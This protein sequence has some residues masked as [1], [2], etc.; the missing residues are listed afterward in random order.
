MGKSKFDDEPPPVHPG[1]WPQGATDKRPEKKKLNG[2]SQP[3]EVVPIPKGESAFSLVERDIPDP[4][5]LCDPWATEG[6]NII[7]GRP[8]L[9]KTT[10]ERQKLAAAATGGDYLDSKFNSPIKCAF[11]SLEEGELLCRLKFKAAG[12]PE[13]ALASIQ[14]HFEWPRGDSGVQLLDRYLTENPDIRLVC[15]D[16]LTRFRMIPDVRMPAFMADYDAINLLHEMAKK[17]PGVVIDVIHHT[18]KAKSDDPIDDVS[19]TYGLTAACDSVTVLRHHADGALM[20]VAGRMWTRSENQYLM[21]RGERQ[22]WQFVGVNLGLTDQQAQ[23]YEII[24][25]DSFGIGGKELGDKLGITQPS[26]WYLINQ[27]QEA[28]VVVRRHG[29]AYAK[30]KM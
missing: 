14:L 28:G 2:S 26:A 22:S 8:K 21:R 24:K 5:R 4:V 25:A 13:S 23:A 17:H 10:L 18:R 15:I 19:G 27:L 12:F 9:G 1:E 7:A 11:L 20:Y 16:S 6:I 3:P 30:E 29:K